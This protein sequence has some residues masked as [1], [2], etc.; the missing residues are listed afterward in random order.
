[1][2]TAKQNTATALASYVFDTS[3]YVQIRTSVRRDISTGRLINTPQ[4]E[5]SSSKK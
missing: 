3:E 1:M 2:A 5:K 4:K